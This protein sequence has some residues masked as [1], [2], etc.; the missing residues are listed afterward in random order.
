MAQCGGAGPWG[1]LDGRS[2]LLASHPTFQERV[3]QAKQLPRA[4]HTEDA[5]TLHLFEKPEIVEQALTD[6]LTD[7]VARYLLH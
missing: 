2:L 6:L 4:Q 1:L 5:P 3:E 7:G